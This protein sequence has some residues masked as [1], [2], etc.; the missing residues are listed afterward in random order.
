MLRHFAKKRLKI[1]NNMHLYPPSPS[2]WDL[3]PYEVARFGGELSKVMLKSLEQYIFEKSYAK[4]RKIFQKLIL[5]KK[6]PP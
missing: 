6:A 5:S 3:P 4:Q 1:P 2:I